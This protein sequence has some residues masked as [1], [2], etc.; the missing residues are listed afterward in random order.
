MSR[1]ILLPPERLQKAVSGQDPPYIPAASGKNPPVNLNRCSRNVLWA[2]PGKR[3]VIIPPPCM[4]DG[5]KVVIFFPSSR[6]KIIR[7]GYSKNIDFFLIL[8]YF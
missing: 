8:K 3:D 7:S 2:H 4:P 1:E 6:E 5:K